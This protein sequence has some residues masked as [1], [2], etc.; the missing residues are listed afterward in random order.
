MISIETMKFRAKG[1]VGQ[2][3][4]LIFWRGKGRIAAVDDT[5]IALLIRGQRV[6]LTWDRLTVTWGRLVGNFTLTVDELGGQ[7][8]AVGIVSLFAFV[9][10]DAVDVID[11]DG[12]LALREREGKPVHQYADVGRPS[13]WGPWRRKIQGD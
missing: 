4:P 2:E 6:D 11:A 12:L 1:M 13:T 5:S 8:D 3:F 7:A 10:S 9:Q